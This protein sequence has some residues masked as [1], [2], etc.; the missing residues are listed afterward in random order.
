MYT[1]SEFLDGV[2]QDNC[3]GLVGEVDRRTKPFGLTRKAGQLPLSMLISRA[4]PNVI[5]GSAKNPFTEQ[6]GMIRGQAGC[7][8]MGSGAGAAAAVSVRTGTDVIDVDVK[9]VQEEL[10]NQGVRL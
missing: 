6:W 8:V 4:A 3:I 9:T 7:L 2:P 5:V 10:R 1:R